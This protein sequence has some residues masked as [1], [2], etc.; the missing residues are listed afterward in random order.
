M[1]QNNLNE[2]LDRYHNGT[3]SAA[4]TKLLEHWFAA[5]T[6]LD[7]EDSALADYPR[8]HLEMWAGVSS[9][10]RKNPVTENTKTVDFKRKRIWWQWSAAAVLLLGLGLGWL[11]FDRKTAENNFTADIAPGIQGAILTLADG[12]KLELSKLKEGELAREA[13]ARISKT[14]DGQLVYEVLDNGTAGG[15]N[16]L[17]T[18]R[19]ESY[20][21][22]LPDGTRVWLNAASSIS[23]PTSFRD[24]ASRSVTL[25]GEA[26]FEVAKKAG[27]PFLVFSGNQQVKVLGTHFNVEAYGQRVATTLLEGKVQV[28]LPGT[29]QRRV[30]APGQQSVNLGEAFSV[31]EVDVEDVVAWKEGYLIFDGEKL[32]DIMEKVARW[33]DIEVLYADAA[34]RGKRYYGSVSRSVKL[35]EVLKRLEKVQPVKF[36]LKGRTV[37]VSAK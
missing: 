21:L 23:Y 22:S 33:Y 31:G 14:A 11:F 12:R 30:L 16:T 8:V 4:E 20:A 36:S 27:Q 13:G 19:G 2:L 18:Q 3:A 28:S 10:L 6:A 25:S 24:K 9:S 5:Q 34:I 37:T 15:T 1:D 29:A 7:K 35:S 26:Y 17:A 32:E